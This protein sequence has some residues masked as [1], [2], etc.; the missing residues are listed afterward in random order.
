MRRIALLCLVAVLCLGGTARA[1]EF[2][3]RSLTI[4]DIWS[5]ATT[6][7]TGVVYLTIRNDGDADRLV[8]ASTN[9]AG[10][11]QIHTTTRDGDIVRMR[12]VD[13]VDIPDH[14][15]VVFKPGG[16]HVML[17]GL[18]APLV[19]GSSLPLKLRFEKAGEVTV[20]VTVRPPGAGSSGHGQ[21][22]MDMSGGMKMHMDN[23]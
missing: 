21:M 2:K 5:R 8:A 11:A 22:D 23:N 18:K 4:V 10:K 6:G 12:P 9:A 16:L 14:T 13:G 1:A 3:A 15:K 17:M 7:K 19:A 20:A